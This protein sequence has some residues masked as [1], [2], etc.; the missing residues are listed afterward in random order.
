MNMIRH[1][2]FVSLLVVAGC[3][4][5]AKTGVPKKT[6]PAGTTWVSGVGRF[7]GLEVQIASVTAKIK[8]TEHRI[9]IIVRF[10]N[11]SEQ[12]VTFLAPVPFPVFHGEI[13]VICPDGQSALSSGGCM[14]KHLMEAVTFAAGETKEFK[15]AAL[16]QCGCRPRSYP[17]PEGKGVSSL[18]LPPGV[19][20]L[21]LF[22]CKPVKIEVEK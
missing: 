2:L 1:L 16:G 6:E 10:R 21:Q 12:S 17:V 11:P 5:S 20:T 18:V 14:K 4:S 7:V 15:V 22:G 8:P 19:Y 3:G 9:P 13:G